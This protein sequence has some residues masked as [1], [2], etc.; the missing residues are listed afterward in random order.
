[1]SDDVTIEKKFH[2]I[3][4]AETLLKMK[5]DI[6]LHEWLSVLRKFYCY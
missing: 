2:K 6:K 1:M 3:I 4:F 5:V